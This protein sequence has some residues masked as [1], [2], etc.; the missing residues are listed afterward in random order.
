[1]LRMTNPLQS[2]PWIQRLLNGVKTFPYGG[3]TL[4]ILCAAL[5]SGFLVFLLQ[6]QRSAT[7][8][9]L[10]M[11]VFARSHEAAYNRMIPAF[12]E[13]HNVRVEVQL[14]GVR[15]LQGRL[16][17]ALQTGAAVPDLIELTSASMGFFTRG[18]LEDIGFID[19][20]D[21]LHEEGLYERFVSTRFAPWTTRNRIF[22][23]PNDV[24]PVALA[25][26]R[27]LIESLGIDVDA[28]KTWDDFVAMGRQ[29]TRDITG[30]GVID[31]YALE[32]PTTGG[33]VLQLLL[34]QRGGQLFDSDGRVA[35]DSPEVVDTMLWYVEQAA[36]PQSIGYDAGSGQ[37]L[38]RAMLDGLV[39]FY[40]TPDWRTRQIEMDAPALAGKMALMPLPAWEEGGIH[41]ST[42][43]GTG[44]VLTRSSANPELAWA[45]AQH[46]Y[47]DT[48]DAASRFRE[49]NIVPPLLES[50]QDDAFE[51]PRAFWND[52]AIGTLYTALA[53]EVPAIYANPYQA[54]ANNKLNE[55]YTL[56][57]QFYLANGIDGLRP[58]IEQTLTDRANQVRRI[59]R[60]NVF[61][62][63]GDNL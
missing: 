18:S 9:D 35:F 12:E 37:A 55:A 38:V 4:L 63:E 33:H 26:R 11:V 56:A 8:A 30:D 19:L 39:L 3:A 52:Q 48:E 58:F 29:V 49:M 6:A 31:R 57:R 60:R 14:V 1:M 47:L 28:L 27:D 59:M 10:V 51:E 2:W 25:Y 40:F 22:A 36:G 13:K 20:T 24:H 7:E 46:L 41:T 45:L 34:A 43:G 42:W 61:L 21:R 54:L 15:A 50:W 53:P 17:S 16:Q 32:M 23:M 44:L 62:E 5:V